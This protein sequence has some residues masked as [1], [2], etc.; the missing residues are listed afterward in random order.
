MA[1][2]KKQYEPRLVSAATSVLL[3]IGHLLHPYKDG[4]VI[5]GGS[6]PGLI[7]EDAPE[8]HIG[9]ID[10]DIA[11]NQNKIPE[12]DY[13]TIRQL[14]LNRGYS[15]DEQP[16]SFTRIVM[17]DGESIKVRVD[18]LAGEYGGTGK[19]HR[20]QRIQDMRPRKA[21]AC[22]LAFDQ[23][24]SKKIQGTLPE[25]GKDQVVV[26]VASIV[27][28][29]MMKAQALQ[30]RMKEKD[31][32]DIYYCL[33]FYPGGH[34]SLVN[35]FRSFPKNRLVDEGLNILRDKF[36]SP[37]HIGPVFVANFLEEEDPETQ[38]MIRRDAFERVQALVNALE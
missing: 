7:L 34:S 26:Q 18:F 25:G 35:A 32:Y 8:P 29:L 14:L 22:D 3:E 33:H 9:S 19:S 2:S 23:T 15:P 12:T 24:I 31:A 36:L 38:E 10:V 11:L 21:R 28:F 1:A 30:G 5:V 27:P 37:D 17:V 20:T 4:L 13:Q 16:F 6:V